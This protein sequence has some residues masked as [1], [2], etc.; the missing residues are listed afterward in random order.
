MFDSSDDINE[1]EEAI[2]ETSLN[3]LE[4]DYLHR[5]CK[6]YHATVTRNGITNIYLLCKNCKNIFP[7]DSFGE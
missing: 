5:N 1:G 2:F 7:L 3:L 4:W 6:R